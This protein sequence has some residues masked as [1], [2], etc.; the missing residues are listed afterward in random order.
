MGK[1]LV[2]VI[3]V[4]LLVSLVLFS[5]TYTVKYHQVGQFTYLDR[6]LVRLFKVLVG[7]MNGY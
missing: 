3:G 6:A 4:V 7:S 5:A 2:I 1:P